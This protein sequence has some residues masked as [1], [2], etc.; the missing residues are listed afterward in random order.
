MATPNVARRTKPSRASLLALAALLAGCSSL[1]GID[2]LST[3]PRDGSA[4]GSG[5]QAGNHTSGGTGG[6]NSGGS[7]GVPGGRNGSGGGNGAHGGAGGSTGGNGTGGSNTGGAAGS[8]AN[9]GAGATGH[10]GGTGGAGGSAGDA[11][12]GAGEGGG[13][14]PTDSTVHGTIIDFWQHPVA[15]VPVAI[16]DALTMTD[17]NGKF[18]IADVPKQYDASFVIHW[19]NP[20]SSYGWVFQGLSRRDPTLQVTR[21]FSSRETR[22]VITQTHGDFTSSDAKWLLAF[23]SDSGTYVASSESNGIDVRPE[24]QGPSTNEWTVH[25]LFLTRTGDLPTAYTAYQHEAV[26]STDG[27][28]GHYLEMDLT[29][30]S[31]SSGNI[32]GSVI[33]NTGVGRANSVFVRFTSGGALPIVD[34]VATSVAPYSYIVPQLANGSITVAA[35]EDDFNADTYAVAHRDGHGPGDTGV[36]LEIPVPAVPITP[37]SGNTSVSD[38]T[39]FSFGA[40]DPDNSGYLIHIEDYSYYQGMYIVTS[41]RQFKLGELPILQGQF[42]LM[43]AEVHTWNVQTHGKF[44]STDDMAGPKGYLDAFALGD[45][46]PEGPANGDGS[47]THSARSGFTTAP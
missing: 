30:Q 27:D 15:N 6:A 47:F 46:Q 44:A 25:S 35:I 39:T 2:D 22:F 37:T 7:A 8:A 24:W 33:Q 40:G 10:T 34:A 21:A 41:R 32:T 18:T 31:I 23:G 3:N 42:K 17:A 1:L 45:E 4:A 11:A 38:T 12:G 5:A 19:Q 13:G 14:N 28:A 26:P 16:G 9:A 29:P 36:D 20:D 43:P